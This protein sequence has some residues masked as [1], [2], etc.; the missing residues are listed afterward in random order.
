VGIEAARGARGVELCAFDPSPEMVRNAER[1]ARESGVER[2]TGRVGFGEDPPFPAAGERP[3][4]LVL[5]SGVASFAPDIEAWLDGLVSTLRPGGTLVVGDVNRDSLGMRVRRASKPL[6]PIREMNARTGGDVRSL[7][8]Q[9]GLRL[10]QAAGY[11]L[12][13]PVPKLQH[14]S[15]TRLRG[16]FSPPLLGL[17]ALAAGI[18]RRL[19]GPLPQCFD[20]WV[21][22]LEAAP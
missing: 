19:G 18:D 20:S 11:Q 4:D 10:R 7:L 8:E 13:S 15:D 17:N 5:S 21:L 3:F 12:T 16:W 14:L 1:N 9:R 2:F 6:L 22:R